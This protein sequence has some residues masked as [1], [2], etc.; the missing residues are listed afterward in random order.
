MLLLSIVMCVFV[1]LGKR[2]P[3]WL[4]TLRLKLLFWKKSSP[5]KDLWEFKT[6]FHLCKTIEQIVK[7]CIMFKYVWT[8][9]SKQRKK[10]TSLLNSRIAYYSLVVWIMCV[11]G[12]CTKFAMEL[13]PLGRDVLVLV[14]CKFAFERIN[15]TCESGHE[16]FDHL[17]PIVLVE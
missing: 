6:L 5:R 13:C 11:M 9:V 4:G 10:V 12:C 7:N 15:W 1:L 14:L 2:V 16:C 3:M 17:W 8:I